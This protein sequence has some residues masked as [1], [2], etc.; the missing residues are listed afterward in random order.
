VDKKFDLDNLSGQELKELIE[1]KSIDVAMLNTTSLQ[2]LMDYETDM[3][4]IGEGDVELLSNCA[5]LISNKAHGG[6]ANAGF[7]G[8]VQ[9]AKTARVKASAAP[10]TVKRFGLK[11]TLGIAAAIITAVACFAMFTTADESDINKHLKKFVYGND[12]V[13]SLDGFTIQKVVVL[14]EY[15]TVEE[16]MEGESLSN[17][18]YPSKLPQGVSI[19]NIQVTNQYDCDKKISFYMDGDTVPIYSIDI[20]TGHKKAIDY[21]GCVTYTVGDIVYIT[22]YPDD[23]IY[24]QNNSLHLM[25]WQAFTRY[26]NND[27]YIHAKTY[28]DLIY[29]LENMEEK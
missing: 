8:M 28:E 15:T 17:I 27:F 13:V 18:L 11:R 6:F 25:R 10:R 22:S 24:R 1:S 12:D 16:L 29:I 7:A 3:L 20:N 5:E 23:E 4:C 26:K 9:N 19:D 14:N 2:R 21:E